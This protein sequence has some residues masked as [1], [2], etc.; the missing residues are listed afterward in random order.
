MQN[1]LRVADGRIVGFDFAAAFAV[2]AALGVP[3]AAVAEWLPGI[4]AV[5]VREMNRLRQEA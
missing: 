3:A 1:Q 5:A 4:E 2:A